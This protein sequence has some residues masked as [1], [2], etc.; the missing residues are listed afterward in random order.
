M[1]FLVFRL[2]NYIDAGYTKNSGKNNENPRIEDY[3]S[4]TIVYLRNGQ[5]KLFAQLSI[6]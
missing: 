5:L 3:G 1:T 6:Q 4:A 2:S